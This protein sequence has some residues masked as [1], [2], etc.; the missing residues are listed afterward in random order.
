MRDNTSICVFSAAIQPS[1]DE[2]SAREKGTCSHGC[3]VRW[4]ERQAEAASGFPGGTQAA[5]GGLRRAFF[6]RQAMELLSGHPE[7]AAMVPPML[8]A[9]TALREQCAILH[10]MRLKAVRSDHTCRQL[11]HNL[12]NLPPAPS[13]PG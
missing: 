1:R 10:K 4:S 5:K 8:I 6:E 9:R 7:L 2:A 3:R 11:I 12:F 13:G